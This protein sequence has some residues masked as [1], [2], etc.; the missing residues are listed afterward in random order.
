VTGRAFHNPVTE[1]TNEIF[2]ERAE[3][4]PLKYA[5]SRGTMPSFLRDS[6]FSVVRDFR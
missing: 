3:R 2:L 1:F 5:P 6:V 4:L